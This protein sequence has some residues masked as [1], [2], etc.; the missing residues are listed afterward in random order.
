MEVKMLLGRM[1][2]PNLRNLSL[3]KWI[4]FRFFS[5]RPGIGEVVTL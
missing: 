1:N 3:G 2:G 4:G 5:E